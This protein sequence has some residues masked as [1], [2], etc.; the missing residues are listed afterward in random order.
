MEFDRDNKIDLITNTRM[1]NFQ[2]GNLLKY[3]TRSLIELLQ[4]EKELQE[5]EHMA[6]FCQHDSAKG[7]NIG[8]INIDEE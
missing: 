3:K 1:R 2:V 5:E 8:D 6:K 7:W 4:S